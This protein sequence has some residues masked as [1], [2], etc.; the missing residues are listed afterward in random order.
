MNVMVCNQF[1]YVVDF[2]YAMNIWFEFEINCD[3][4]FISLVIRQDIKHGWR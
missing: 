2:E 1:G 4:M 3:L